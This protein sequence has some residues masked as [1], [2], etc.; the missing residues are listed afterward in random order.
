VVRWGWRRLAAA[1]EPAV[2]YVHPWEIDPDQPRQKTGWRIRVN[3]YHNLGRTEDRLRQLLERIRFASMGDVLRRLESL[4]RLP[5]YRFPE[6]TPRSGNGFR[7]E[8]ARESYHG[9]VAGERSSFPDSSSA[10][11]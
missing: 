11:G 6:G 9:S 10:L 3:H 8:P 1:D 2:L 5:S 4:D 7:S